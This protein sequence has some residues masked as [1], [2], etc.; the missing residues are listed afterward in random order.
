MAMLNIV[1]YCWITRGYLLVVEF[2][3]NYLT[4]SEFR[5]ARAP[6]TPAGGTSRLR[7]KL[8]SS[9]WNSKPCQPQRAKSSPKSN[10][11]ILFSP[12]TAPAFDFEACYCSTRDCVESR[13]RL[14]RFESHHVFSGSHV[15]EICPFAGKPE[16]ICVLFCLDTQHPP[17]SRNSEDFWQQIETFRTI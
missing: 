12:G 16:W 10:K 14:G 15:R 3:V 17:S 1:E 13:L 11:S 7:E 8:R 2:H 4:W 5:Y 6:A 9:M